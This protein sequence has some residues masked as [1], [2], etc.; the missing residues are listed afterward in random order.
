MPRVRL[1]TAALPSSRLRKRR[2]L[3]T[4]VL[5]CLAVVTLLFALGYVAWSET[6][7]LSRVE[8]VGAKH[9]AETLLENV[10]LDIFES[11]YLGLLPKGHSIFY[12]KANIASAL[13]SQ[14]PRLSSV[15]SKVENGALRITVTEYPEARVWCGDACYYMNDGG[16]LFAPASTG[17]DLVIFR[18]S[19]TTEGR[20]GK[21]VYPEMFL[22]N[23]IPLLELFSIGSYDVDSVE[24]DAKDVNLT[25][26]D[27]FELRFLMADDYNSVYDKTLKILNME[28]VQEKGIQKL[29]YVDLRFGNKVYYKFEDE[30]AQ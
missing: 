8:V 1:N 29:S 17:T 23:I 30:E 11:R 20:L 28:E 25:M 14:F 5:Y 26:G 4:A 9:V 10:S 2:Y 3:A 13:L 21:I 12:P 16:E 7:H 27:G 15:S 24:L 18:S 22:N 19:G 6:F